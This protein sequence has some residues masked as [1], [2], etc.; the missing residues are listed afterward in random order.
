MPLG[1]MLLDGEEPR[2]GGPLTFDTAYKKPGGIVL[3]VLRK[4]LYREDVDVFI[5]RRDPV[6]GEIYE[7]GPQSA[8]EI[9]WTQPTH[10]PHIIPD[11][12]TSEPAPVKDPPALPVLPPIAVDPGPNG[13]V[14]TMAPPTDAQSLTKPLL[15]AG[16]V[17]AALFL[18]RD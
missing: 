2:T 5:L 11:A 6:T 12:P 14:H 4:P 1:L 18:L 13:V 15:V 16:A 9:P 3:P 10:G 7:T 17:V 8:D